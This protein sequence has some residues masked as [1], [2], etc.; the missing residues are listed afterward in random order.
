MNP[1]RARELFGFDATELLL[2]DRPLADV[3]RR[4]VEADRATVPPP[5]AS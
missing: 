3:V 4:L 1:D 5:R 2:M